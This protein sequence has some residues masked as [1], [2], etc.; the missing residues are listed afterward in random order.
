MKTA[1]KC[2]FIAALVAILASAVSADAGVSV[3]VAPQRDVHDD[4]GRAVLGVGV[5]VPAFDLELNALGE[6]GA[7]IRN[8]THMDSRVELTAGYPLGTGIVR[9]T[10][11]GGGGH[12]RWTAESSQGKDIDTGYL[13][14]GARATV[15][16]VPGGSVFGELAAQHLNEPGAWG[17]RG[18]LGFSL[19]VM[20][21]S[22][23]YEKLRYHDDSG[24]DI[25]GF[26]VGVGF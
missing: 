5:R 17:Y 7:S 24:P 12:R 10:P 8:E 23:T 2:L 4:Y 14:A 13:V 26:K 19:A 9:V 22:V 16:P 18:E 20:R 3:Y 6:V 1:M 11:F 21:Y 15:K 25:Y